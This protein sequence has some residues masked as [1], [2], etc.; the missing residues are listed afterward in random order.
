MTSDGFMVE[1]F[2]ARKDINGSVAVLRPSMDCDVRLGDD[3]HTADAVRAEL[4]KD[5]LDDRAVAGAD[6]CHQRGF[7]RVHT[8]QLLRIAIAVFD[9][10]VLTE[11]THD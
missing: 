11:G 1:F 4:V 8:F 2:T 9:K 6:G 3:N 10:S 5:R 7:D